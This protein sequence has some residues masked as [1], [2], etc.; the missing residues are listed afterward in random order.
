MHVR[1]L[2]G[3]TFVV[4]VV[5]L[6]GCGGGD[7]V[8]RFHVS[9]SVNYEGKPVPAGTITFT[10]AKGNEGPQGYAKITEGKY[11][12][13]S[14]K[15]TVGGPMAVHI[16]GFDGV[17]SDKMP[18]GKQIFAYDTKADLPKADGTKDFDV[19]AKDAKDMK[20]KDAKKG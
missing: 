4:S 19:K 11:D 3:F 5:L 8:T 12:T 1:V 20:G 14:G 6:A 2:G 9:G 16:D 18:L 7:S 15:G 17:A 10:P 13:H